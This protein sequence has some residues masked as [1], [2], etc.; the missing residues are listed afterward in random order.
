MWLSLC[1]GL[2]VKNDGQEIAST[3][4]TQSSREGQKNICTVW[5]CGEPRH[6][7]RRL[8]DNFIELCYGIFRLCVSPLV[9]LWPLPNPWVTLW[10]HS[11]FWGSPFSDLINHNTST[12]AAGSPSFSG[13]CIVFFL[14]PSLY[15]YA[16]LILSLRSSSFSLITCSKLTLILISVW[17]S[18]LT[19]YSVPTFLLPPTDTCL[20]PHL[21]HKT[22]IWW[23]GSFRYCWT[24]LPILVR[25]QVW[26]PLSQIN[27]IQWYFRKQ[28]TSN[29]VL[30][31]SSSLSGFSRRS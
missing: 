13:C 26:N 31:L 25:V 8:Q 3:V 20:T 14:S 11:T 6:G 16:A 30:R 9:A 27:I 12:Q 10:R 28:L 24:F 19:N 18:N 5:F 7:Q 22:V 29:F 2:W 23:R 17:L 4:F 21:S 1:R 15:R